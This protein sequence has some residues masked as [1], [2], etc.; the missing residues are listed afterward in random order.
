MTHRFLEREIAQQL[1]EIREGKMFARMFGDNWQDEHT[2]SDLPKLL[3]HAFAVR[4]KNPWSQAVIAERV[5][6]SQVTLSQWEC[7]ART[8]LN[9]EKYQKWCS[10]L[11]TTYE[12]EV[13]KAVGKELACPQTKPEK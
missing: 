10:V 5:G 6:V 7:G 8:P 1:R 4:E 13:L 12:N 2:V 11:G 9:L 3:N